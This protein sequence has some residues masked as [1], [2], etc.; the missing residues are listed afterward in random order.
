M[1][2]HKNKTKCEEDCG[3]QTKVTIYCC[4]CGAVVEVTYV[5]NG[6]SDYDKNS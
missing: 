3:K 6:K 2:D 5:H 4:D 1:C